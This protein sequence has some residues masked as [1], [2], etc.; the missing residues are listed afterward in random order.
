MSLGAIQRLD[1]IVRP[2]RPEK[3]DSG[4]KTMLIYV[5]DL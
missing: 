2:E 5:Y 1:R 4:V 3:I